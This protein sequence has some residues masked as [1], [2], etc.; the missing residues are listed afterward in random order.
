MP[1]TY[2]KPNPLKWACIYQYFF[3]VPSFTLQCPSFSFSFPLKESP[4]L[5]IAKIP[6]VHFWLVCSICLSIS[7]ELS[8]AVALW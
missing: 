4:S 7:H 6:K 8:V 3:S 1:L 5:F 2:I